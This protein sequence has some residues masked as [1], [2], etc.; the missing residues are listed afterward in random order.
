[1]A[2]CVGS[3]H[4]A[5]LLLGS[6]HSDSSE[7]GAIAASVLQLDNCQGVFACHD[8]SLVKELP[9]VLASGSRNVPV[10]IYS[11]SGFTLP[12]LLS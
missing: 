12:S 10:P 11:A 6:S 9:S 7:A 1:M 8:S 5:A 3:R 2:S 4:V